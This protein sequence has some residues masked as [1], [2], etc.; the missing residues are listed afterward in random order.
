MMQ[1]EN[2]SIVHKETAFTSAFLGEELSYY[3]HRMFES[4]CF[5]LLLSCLCVYLEHSQLNASL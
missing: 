3:V 2:N 1:T 5:L 4:F